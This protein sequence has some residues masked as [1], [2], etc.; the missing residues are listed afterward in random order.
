[1]PMVTR[2]AAASTFCR[3]DSLCA[4]Q[5]EVEAPTPGAQWRATSPSAGLSCG[6]VI[7]GGERARS[8]CA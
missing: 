5:S 7:G 3:L 2:C 1:M 4:P 6:C 8:A